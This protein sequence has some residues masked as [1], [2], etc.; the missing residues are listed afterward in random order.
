MGHKGTC[1]AIVDG[2]MAGDVLYDNW[3]VFVTSFPVICKLVCFAALGN[4]VLLMRP[5]TDELLV[6][7]AVFV[8]GCPISARV[9]WR[10]TVCLQ[11]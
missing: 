6:V 7:M 11:L 4:M 2:K 5:C 1:C 8:W 3:H 10:G 9:T